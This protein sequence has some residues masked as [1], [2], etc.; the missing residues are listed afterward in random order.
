MNVEASASQIASPAGGA[1]DVPQPPNRRGRPPRIGRS[2][3]VAAAIELGLERFSL[4][5]IASRL[6]VTTPAL[7]SHVSGRDE[8]LRLAAAE[9]INETT[10]ALTADVEWHEWLRR[11]ADLLRGRLATVG[12]ELLEAIGDRLDPGT[13][14][15]AEQGLKLLSDAGFTAEDSAYALWLVARTAFTAGPPGP[16]RLLGPVETARGIVGTEAGAE[17]LDAMDAVSNAD[18]DS[19][20][21]FDMAVLIAGLADRLDARAGR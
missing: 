6:E 19:S 8:I 20:F 16:Q 13:L 12:P 9:V 4:D 5:A 15:S 3:I 11:W 7:Y 1:G 21:R 17:M 2:E 10:V 18:P 14:N